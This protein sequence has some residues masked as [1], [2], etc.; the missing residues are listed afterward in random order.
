MIDTV[1]AHAKLQPENAVIMPKWKGDS[2]DR[3][4]VS[5][6]PFLEYVATMGFTDTRTVLKSFENKH[7]P[8]EFAKREAV[9]RE[10]FEKQLADERA[11]RP[12]R[13]GV[14]LLGSALGIKSHGAGIDGMEQTAAEGFERG[15]ML[16]D[17]IRERG[18]K[19]YEMIEKEIREN[20]E[21]WLKEMAQE[22]EKAKEEQMK[23]MKSSLSGMFGGAGK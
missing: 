5:L 22:E 11:K 6:I 19:Q 15:Q 13:S 2:Q 4:L 23:G 3:E 10:R 14:G 1:P 9:A 17:Q 16:Q 20:G 12:K 8:T 18:Q 21:K 7:I